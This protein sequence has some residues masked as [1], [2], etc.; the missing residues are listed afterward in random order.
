MYLIFFNSIILSKN[1]GFFLYFNIIKHTYLFLFFFTQSILKKPSTLVFKKSNFL[2]LKK[3]F[4]YFLILKEKNN[5]H[6]NFNVFFN[7]IDKRINI[8][9]YFENLKLITNVLYSLSIKNLNVFYINDF[10][11]KNEF[12]T[13][14]R[15][16]FKIYSFEKY[17]YFCH[18]NVKKI[19][20]NK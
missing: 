12:T 9:L 14:N 5:I 7:K 17:Q 19:R 18:F 1:I 11:L 15:F 4:S 3:K 2:V 13:F 20:T 10:F 6:W 16:F 8:N